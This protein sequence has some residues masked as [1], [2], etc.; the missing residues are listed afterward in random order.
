ML[1]FD[2]MIAP[3][4][5]RREVTIKGLAGSPT[6]TLAPA[7]ATNPRWIE[8]VLGREERGLAAPAEDA[9]KLDG[10]AALRAGQEQA[11]ELAAMVNASCLVGVT[12]DDGAGNRVSY[13]IEVGERIV[14]HLATTAPAAFFSMF[15]ALRAGDAD[16]GITAELEAV[17][18]EA[19]GA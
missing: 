10:L 6:L 16:P 18:G 19:N 9:P 14:R 2:E 3:T 1:T 4:V 7:N 13:P 15:E 17:A 5:R 12:A 8:W 11:L